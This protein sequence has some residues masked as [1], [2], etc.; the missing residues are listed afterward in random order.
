MIPQAR[1][2]GPAFR[3]GLVT[4]TSGWCDGY[5]QA[6]LISVPRDLAWDFLLFAQ[7]NPKPCPVLDVIDAGEVAGPLADGDIRTDVPAT[8][9]GWT[10]S[11]SRRPPDARAC[12]RDGP[13]VLPDRLQLHLRGGAAAR[14]A[15]RCGTSSRA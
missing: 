3:A 5:T 1:P 6:N 15:C 9:S 11:W 2:P 8:A 13:R 10:V 14:R 4:P 12:W 7:R